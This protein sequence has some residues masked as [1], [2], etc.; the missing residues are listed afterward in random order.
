MTLHRKSRTLSGQTEI[1]WGGSPEESREDKEQ[2]WTQVPCGKNHDLIKAVPD[3]KRNS[4]QQTAE[5]R[6]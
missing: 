2:E 6:Q 1:G 4:K 5:T 3:E